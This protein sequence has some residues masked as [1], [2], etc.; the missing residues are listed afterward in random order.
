[1]LP[2]CEAELSNE[3]ID[4]FGFDNEDEDDYYR[5]LNAPPSRNA[6]APG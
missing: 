4:F 5:G 3:Q 2:P 1:M 6:L